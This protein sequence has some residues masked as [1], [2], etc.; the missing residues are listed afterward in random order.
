M[1]IRD[2]NGAIYKL[3]GPNKLME[4]QQL[5][6]QQHVRIINMNFDRITIVDQ[7]NPHREF[8][9]SYDVVDIGEELGLVDNSVTI[10]A[11]KFIDEINEPVQKHIID[12]PKRMLDRNSIKI[13]C[14]PVVWKKTVDSLYGDVRTTKRYGNKFVFDGVVVMD[15]DLAMRFWSETEIPKESVVFPQDGQ[16]RC[17]KVDEIEEKTGGYLMTTSISDVNPDF[18]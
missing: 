6:D 3:R 10:S 1:A 8:I 13:W 5:W 15:T 11:Q 9:E 16:K 12:R 17:W 2:R 18:S 4:N 14:V 7:N